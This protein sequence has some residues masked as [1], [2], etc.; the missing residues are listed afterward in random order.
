MSLQS[1]SG[2]AALCLWSVAAGA[3]LCAVYDLFRLTRLDRKVNPVALF[4]ADLAYCLIAAATF[5]VLFF[6][7]T[8]GN[9]RA[10]AF[11]S[12]AGGFILWRKT[13]S[14]LFIAAARRVKRAVK[15]ALR[16]LAKRIRRV[17][18]AF[19]LDISTRIYKARVLRDITERSKGLSNEKEE[20]FKT[21]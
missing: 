20:V 19:K 1:L 18:S 4:L 6:N 13:V 21:Q 8:R 11:V 14:R 10:I 7:L 2:G 15:K 5:A 12:A 9:V 3:F 16:A 17:A